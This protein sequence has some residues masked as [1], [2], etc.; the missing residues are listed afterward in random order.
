MRVCAVLPCSAQAS[1]LV[2]ELVDNELLGEG[3]LSSIADARRRLLVP[4]AEV[5]PRGAALFA[6][7]VQLKVPQRGGFDLSDFDT[8]YANAAFRTGAYSN[9]AR[10]AQPPRSPLR[11]RMPTAE[12]ADGA[13]ASQT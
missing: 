6:L 2:C 1:L 10:K 3:T 9:D 5:V 13:D 12:S 11:K 7:P 4:G 8:F